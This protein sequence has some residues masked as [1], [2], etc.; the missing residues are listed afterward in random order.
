MDEKKL[1]MAL[2]GVVEDAV[3]VVGA[4]LNVASDVLLR[5]FSVGSFPNGVKNLFQMFCTKLI[6]LY[7][8]SVPD[9]MVSHIASSIRSKN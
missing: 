7:R 4:D 1:K 6:A 2:D 8:C 5:Y 9:K 3:A